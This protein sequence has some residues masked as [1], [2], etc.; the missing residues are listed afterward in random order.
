M[1][2]LTV[3]LVL[4]QFAGIALGSASAAVLCAVTAALVAGAGSK[5]DGFTALQLG[6][7]AAA[8]AAALV[9]CAY[10]T[11]GHAWSAAAAMAVVALLSSVAAGAGP[12]AAALGALGSYG[13]VLA[14]VVITVRGA[15]GTVSVAQAALRV[16]VGA[17]V[18]LAIVALGGLVRDWRSPDRRSPDRQRPGRIPSPLP[19]MLRSLRSFDRHARDGVRRAIPLSAGM[20]LLFAWPTR[21]ALWM[22]LAAFAVLSPS[23]KTA[24]SIAAARIASTLLGLAILALA[25]S[26]LPSAVALAMAAG[27]VVVGIAYEPAYPAIGGALAAMGAVLLVALPTGAVGVWALHRLFDTVVGCAVAL[28]AAYLLWPSDPAGSIAADDGPTADGA[29]TLTE[30]L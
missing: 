17:A 7:F 10:L 25:L 6:G 3:G 5:G 27:C 11:A 13:Y 28:A 30:S 14:V 22:F 8:V 9:L 15:E 24:G 29:R 26:V 12:V 19:P 2:Y 21:D 18:G 4:G 23:I 16:A 20:F 1:A